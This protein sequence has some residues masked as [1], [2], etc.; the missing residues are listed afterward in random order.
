[1]ALLQRL[2]WKKWNSNFDAATKAEVA[3]VWLVCWSLW[4]GG[5]A[6]IVGGDG[7]S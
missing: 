2:E 5:F 1:M 3:V 7:D 4:Y 6:A